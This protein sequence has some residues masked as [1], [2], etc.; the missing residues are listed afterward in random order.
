MP[1]SADLTV[2][3][4]FLARYGIIT[5]FASVLLETIGGPTPSESLIVIAALLSTSDAVW[6]WNVILAGWLGGALGGF[7]GFGIGRYGG[8]PALQRYGH[9][10]YLT[11]EI[12]KRTEERIR[13][14]GVWLVIVAQFLPFLRQLKGVAAGAA[15]M[16]WLSFSFANIFGTALWALAWGGGAHFLGQRITGLPGLVQEYAL[17][18]LAMPFA[19]ALI[20]G[21]GLYWRHRRAR[22]KIS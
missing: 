1:F 6:V 14:N 18:I 19:I 2:I 10:I 5:V 21:L 12:L 16:Q 20:T 3:E 13:G 15:G 11:P 4:P 8:R 17:L 22:H 7:I 9:R